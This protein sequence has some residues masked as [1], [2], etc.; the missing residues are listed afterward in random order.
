MWTSPTWAGQSG[1]LA[2][3]RGRAWEEPSSHVSVSAVLEQAAAGQMKCGLQAQREGRSNA[4][5]G[6]GGTHRDFWER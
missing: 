6:E 5:Q 4:A 2:L 3:Q 1:E